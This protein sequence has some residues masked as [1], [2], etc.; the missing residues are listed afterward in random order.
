M[1]QRA[2]TIKPWTKLGEKKWKI[3]ANHVGRQVSAGNNIQHSNIVENPGDK[4]TNQIL[5]YFIKME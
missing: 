4:C 3:K 5:C 1:G 2:D